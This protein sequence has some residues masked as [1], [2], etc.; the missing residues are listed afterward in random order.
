MPFESRR[1]P[2]NV[3]LSVFWV[4]G[5]CR[6]GHFRSVPGGEGGIAASGT[7]GETQNPDVSPWYPQPPRNPRGDVWLSTRSTK[8]YS[9]LKQTNRNSNKN[10]EKHLCVAGG[11]SLS[12]QMFDQNNVIAP[13]PVALFTLSTFSKRLLCNIFAEL[14]AWVYIL[15][16]PAP[17]WWGNK[18]WSGGIGVLSL[19]SDFDLWFDKQE[20]PCC[21]VGECESFWMMNEDWDATSCSILSSASAKTCPAFVGQMFL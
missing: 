19:R 2:A 1:N 11:P 3:S 17:A 9:T 7:G 16:P 8:Q 10:Q 12:Q 5:V 13:R 4:T 14:L 21:I 20:V 6:W 18:Y 15:L